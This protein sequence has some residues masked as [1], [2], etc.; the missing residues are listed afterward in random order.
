MADPG[1]YHAVL[2][3]LNS[4]DRALRLLMHGDP[5]TVYGA[6]AYTASTEFA[7]APESP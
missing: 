5:A 4:K 2:K 1:H 3:D 6:R 7:A